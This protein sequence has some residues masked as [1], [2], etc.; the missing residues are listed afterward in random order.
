MD[1]SCPDL[2]SRTLSSPAVELDQLSP[3]RRYR[4]P[5]SDSRSSPE[6]DSAFDRDQV[7]V[8]LAAA[9]AAWDSVDIVETVVRRLVV[10]HNSVYSD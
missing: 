8:K 6:L 2:A 10:E 1:Q 4:Q 7:G 3:S 5:T 9:A